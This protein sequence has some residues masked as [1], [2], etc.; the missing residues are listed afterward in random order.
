MPR[1]KVRM[2]G[3][4]IDEQSYE[5]CEADYWAAIGSP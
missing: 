4:V 1:V 5:F 2:G 3:N